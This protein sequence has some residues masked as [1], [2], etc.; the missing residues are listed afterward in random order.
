MKAML[1]IEMN[2]AFKNRSF[3]LSLSIGFS[4][5]MAHI[6]M[7]V[8]GKSENPL[9]F[10]G[11]GL[12]Y[13]YSVFNSWIGGDSTNPYLSAYSTIFPILATMPFGI[14]YL[15]DLKKGYVKNIYT[16]TNRI[17]YCV[18]KYVATF[19]MAGIAVVIPMIFNLLIT[20]AMVPSLLP[21]MNG[22]FSIGGGNLWSGMFYMHPYIYVLMY[23]VVYFIYG[24][25]FASLALVGAFF[26]DN[27][28]LLTLFPF[29]V[30]YGLGL[31]APYVYKYALIRSINPALIL[32]ISQPSGITLFTVIAEAL[33][34]GVPCFIIF[35]WG[36]V[37][38]DTL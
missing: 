3:Y 1:K 36:G 31:A 29:I 22:M 4:I 32:T 38:N 16:R 24:G 8:I 9:K 34:I 12:T 35:I 30:Y 20:S 28:F 11:N 21:V 19:V 37:K 25:V 27:M 23:L 15:N 7:V 18:S 33:I 10:F 5:V 14:S 6:I 13:P 17:N 2:R 26:V